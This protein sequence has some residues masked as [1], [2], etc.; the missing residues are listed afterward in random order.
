MD[1]TCSHHF[2]SI[3]I[4]L[5][6]ELALPLPVTI[7]ERIVMEYLSIRNNCSHVLWDACSRS[8]LHLDQPIHCLWMS[9]PPPLLPLKPHPVEDSFLM[10]VEDI[11]FASVP[12]ACSFCSICD[13]ILTDNDK[14][15]LTPEILIT[16][17]VQTKISR[18][19]SNRLARGGII[20]KGGLLN[21]RGR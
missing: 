21:G 4:P 5:I 7:D 12:D 2:L 19:G 10:A 1:T 3:T 20:P 17:E 8:L 6:V 18:W 15:M 14:A 9:P 16:D 13:P 11:R